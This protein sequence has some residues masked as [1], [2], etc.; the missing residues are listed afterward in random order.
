MCGWDAFNLRIEGSS[1]LL[2]LYFAIASGFR[3]LGNFFNGPEVF[4]ALSIGCLRTTSIL[5]WFSE[6]SMLFVIGH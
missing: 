4:L 2:L 3:T 5:D 1:R 6:F